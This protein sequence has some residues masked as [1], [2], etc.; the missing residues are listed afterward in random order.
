M[1]NSSGQS[2]AAI[3][4]SPGNLLNAEAPIEANAGIKP[5]LTEESGFILWML[6][7]WPKA[8][9]P[10]LAS[11]VT[12]PASMVNVPSK[13][14][15]ADCPIDVTFGICPSATDE[16]L[17]VVPRNALWPMVISSEQFPAAMATVPRKEANAESPKD[18]NFG[19][20]PSVTDE[21]R[22]ALGAEKAHEP[23]LRSSG[24]SPAANI[25]LPV[26]PLKASAPIEV[27]AGIN[28][29]VMLLL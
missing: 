27:S 25:N 5:N 1:V 19:I 6:P 21:G 8:W 16:S 7:L 20:F 14:W 23:I 4:S 3:D 12:L 24:K 29:S 11:A 15:N 10:M 18:A 2:P 9:M 13:L 17:L 26:H 22:S 28:P